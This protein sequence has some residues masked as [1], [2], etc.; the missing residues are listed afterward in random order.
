MAAVATPPGY[1]PNPRQAIYGDNPPPYRAA[2]TDAP[3][4]ES[5]KSVDLVVARSSAG[6]DGDWWTLPLLAIGL[7]LIA[8]CVLIPQADVNRRMVYERQ[9]LQLDADQIAKQVKLNE[10]FLHQLQTDPQ[11]AERL[12]Q[13]QMR[14]VRQGERELVLN[15][16]PD[17]PTESPFLLVHLPAP[18]PLPPYE[19]VGGTLGQICRDPHAKLYLMGA[20]L[21]LVA[22]GL[23]LGGKGPSAP[24]SSHDVS[25]KGN[26]TESADVG[27]GRIGPRAV[28]S[29]G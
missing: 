26:G 27:A 29:L 14:V 22:M 6:G 7:G 12:A 10:D 9:N 16:H 20:A 15:L 18:P 2:S 8:C 17:A 21:F 11:L 25:A 19:P 4:A 13:R 23:I 1:R 3:L 28:Q 24:E 5:A